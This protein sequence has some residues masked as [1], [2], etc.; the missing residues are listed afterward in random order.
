MTSRGTDVAQTP[1][2]YVRG[3]VASRVFPR[4]SSGSGVSRARP[5]A[6]RLPATAAPDDALRTKPSRLLRRG[7]DS[8]TTR[9]RRGSRSHVRDGVHVVVPHLAAGLRLKP[10]RR[11]ASAPLLERVCS[12]VRAHQRL[13]A[14]VLH[15]DGLALHTTTSTPARGRLRLHGRAVRVQGRAATACAQLEQRADASRRPRVH[16]RAGLYEAK[17]RCIRTSTPFRAA[18][19]SRT[20]RRARQC[21]S[22]TRPIRRRSRG[23]ASGSS[24][25]STSA[26]TSRC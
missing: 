11:R 6:V 9:R 7:A 19:T 1:G 17:R 13:P 3:A 14:L 18:W 20:S 2:R 23:R 26:S 15:A 24:G 22:R 21:R 8:S 10:S 5:V 4:G 16:R 25:S 12:R